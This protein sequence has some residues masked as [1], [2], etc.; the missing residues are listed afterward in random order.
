MRQICKL[1]S[2]ES[3]RFICA[4]ISDKV[5]LNQHKKK[6]NKKTGKDYAVARVRIRRDGTAAFNGSTHFTITSIYGDANRRRQLYRATDRATGHQNQFVTIANGTSPIGTRDKSH[7]PVVSR[8]SSA[9]KKHDLS[10]EIDPNHAGKKI[11]PIY[12]A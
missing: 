3:E 1:F 8:D 12:L 11:I 6:R 5:I 2:Q 7:R 10:R 9:N 4:H